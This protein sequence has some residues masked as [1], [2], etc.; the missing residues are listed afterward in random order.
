MHANLVFFTG[1][2]N[3]YEEYF[4]KVLNSNY[5]KFCSTLD[6]AV[7]SIR[8]YKDT[9]GVDAE[10][11]K[12]GGYFVIYRKSDGK[13]LKSINWREPGVFIDSKELS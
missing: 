7:Q 2:L 10:Y 8:F 3:Q 11:R 6:E 9:K 13:I 1:I 4:E 5:S 12:V